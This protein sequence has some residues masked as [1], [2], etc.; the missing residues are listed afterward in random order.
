MREAG[1]DALVLAQPETLKYASGAFPGVAT[2]WRRAGAAFLVVGANGVP[3]TAIVGDLQAR[4]FRAQ[5]GLAD[6]R[7]HRLWVETGG[8]RDPSGEA[9]RELIAFEQA[10]GREPG[11]PRPGTFDLRASLGLLRDAFQQRTD[12]MQIQAAIHD[13]GVGIEGLTAALQQLTARVDDLTVRYREARSSRKC[14]PS[15]ISH[16]AAVAVQ[17]P[18]ACNSSSKWPILERAGADGALRCY[19]D[20]QDGLFNVPELLLQ[21]RVGELEGAYVLRFNLCLADGRAV[22]RLRLDE[23]SKLGGVD[24]GGHENSLPSGKAHS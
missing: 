20:G 5:S 22:S 11:R 23:P 10:R 7:E 3:M 24:T 2:F 15:A 8:V 14:L 6:V 17:N 18:A 21:E 9:A 16:G 19:S 12:P 13:V 4:E 1:L